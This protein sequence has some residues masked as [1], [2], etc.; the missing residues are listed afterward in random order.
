MAVKEA[1]MK[2]N[3]KEEKL[4]KKK[5]SKVGSGSVCQMLRRDQIG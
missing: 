5:F 3:I 4:R 1:S 2:Q